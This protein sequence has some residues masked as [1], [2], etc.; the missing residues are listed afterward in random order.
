VDEAGAAGL[1]NRRIWA[2]F[3]PLAASWLMMAAELP[4]TTSIVNRAVDP[5][6][7]TAALLGLVS[8]ALFIESPV[9]D[10]L[11]TSTTFGTSASAYR[12]I[13]NFTLWLMALTGCVHAVVALTPVYD[14]LTKGILKWP[15][16]VAEAA[17]WPM[18]CM[19]PWSP[20]I[21]WR[22]HVQGM[23]IRA[24][25]TR[26]IGAGT[27]LRLATIVVVGFGLSWSGTLPGVTVAAVA[28]VSSV[29]VEAVF[30]EWA[31]R[32]ILASP[33]VLPAEGAGVGWRELARF[34]GPL[35]AATMA[36]MATLPLTSGALA[37]SADH[38][39][40][41]AAWQTSLS[42][43]FPLRTVVFALPEVVIALS[44][45]PGGPTKLFRFCLG[46]GGFLTGLALALAV[47]KFDERFFGVVVG[48][49]S[50]VAQ[51]AHRAFWLTSPLPLIQSVGNY[52]K[53]VL[54]A[55]LNTMA[56]LNST[57]FQTA[58]LGLSLMCGLALGWPGVVVASAA[59]V[60]GSAAECLILGLAWARRPR[61]R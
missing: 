61:E 53:G 9:I 46:V 36:L 56:R 38:V 45:F 21:G 60:A 22:R 51:E 30:V 11:S 5:E 54:T 19:I 3:A 49:P 1:T 16:D 32:R 31:S 8:L 41:M 24:G 4:I 29:V 55:R 44:R 18:V 39:L 58:V 6:L 25:R 35:T 42:L 40:S 37:R 50:P 52:L 14:A 28:L 10:L 15:H 7:N 12:A 2:V 26:M 34:H 23:L 47:F 59:V 43:G 20:A 57:V 17:R 27:G 48:A 13:R 33:A